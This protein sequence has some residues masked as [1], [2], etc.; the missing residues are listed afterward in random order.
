MAAHSR[1]QRPLD[2]EQ[3]KVEPTVCRVAGWAVDHEEVSGWAAAAG[4]RRGWLVWWSGAGAATPHGAGA[5]GVHVRARHRG[6]R[7][8]GT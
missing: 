2:E 5:H 6:G 8:H 1:T 3:V 7:R 4:V